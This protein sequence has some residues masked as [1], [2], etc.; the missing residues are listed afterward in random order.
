M[1]V[2]SRWPKGGWEGGVCSTVIDLRKRIIRCW[3][4]Y[5]T[6]VAFATRNVRA[7][8]V[9]EQGNG[10]L[11]GDAGPFLE[12]AHLKP[13]GLAGSQELAQAVERGAVK[14]QVL[15]DAAQP[16]LAQK[17]FEQGAGAAGLDAGLG[18]DLGDRG[19]GPPRLVG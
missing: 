8:E 13:L 7:V 16:F 11:A 10:V 19:G 15:A 9:F 17:D 14:D 4:Y 5:Q 1:T 3:L 18:Q 12:L 6:P 2:V